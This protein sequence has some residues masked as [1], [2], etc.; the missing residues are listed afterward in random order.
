MHLM[1]QPHGFQNRTMIEHR[2]NSFKIVLVKT[3]A[4]IQL[5]QI[6]K[7]GRFFIFIPQI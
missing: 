1:N 3:H 2:D 6:N 4:H 5:L 7:I